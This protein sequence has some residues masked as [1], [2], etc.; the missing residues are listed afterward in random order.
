MMGVTEIPNIHWRE[1][2]WLLLS[3]QPLI[4]SIALRVRNRRRL[5][6]FADKALF[7]WLLP[8]NNAKRFAWPF[9]RIAYHT[10]WILFC[11]AASGPRY[12]LDDVSQTSPSV[13]DI[14]IVV[15]ASKSMH[16]SDVYPNR[17]RRAKLQILEVLNQLRSQRVAIIVYAAKAHL[18]VPLT[19]DYEAVRF[20]VDGL[21]KLILPTA[22]SRPM[23]A[24]TMAMQE[25]ASS[26]HAK[27]IVLLTDGDNV[28]NDSNQALAEAIKNAGIV[29]VTLG[30][31]TVEGDVIP[32]PGGGWLYQDGKAVISRLQETNLRNFAKS[33]GGY[34]ATV[35]DGDQTGKFLYD[36]VIGKN[37]DT[38]ASVQDSNDVVWRELYQWVMFPAVLL[39]FF[40]VIPYQP[41]RKP[42]TTVVG[43][44]VFALCAVLSGAN[45]AD[46]Q[47]NYDVQT[48]YSHFKNHDYAAAA[49]VFS[50]I[51]GYQGR[52]GEGASR[53][54]M[55]DFNAAVECYSQAVLDADNDH[56]R[57]VALYNLGNSYFQ[58]GNY[59]AAAQVYQDALRY[60]ERHAETLYNLAIS[61]QLDQLVK[62]RS[63]A[64]ALTGRVGRGP[65]HAPAQ[66]NLTLTDND[67]VTLDQSED[68][69]QDRASTPSL[70][71]LTAEQLEFLIQKGLPYVR[72]LGEDSQ[73]SPQTHWRRDIAANL[74]LEKEVSGR[75]WQRLFEI[76]EGFPAP[77]DTPVNEPGIPPW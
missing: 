42:N 65:R 10:A 45:S 59:A 19:H 38:A 58:A 36:Q 15:D 25:L 7:P 12:V 74:S 8:R 9:R 35:Q 68:H 73:N 39:F 11:V 28:G 64:I 70:D 76:E 16:A 63:R 30:I 3:L 56:D 29:L 57:A 62:Q 53:Y 60:R 23:E 37:N 26:P 55:Q 71:K 6:A 22:G 46:A 33:S 32:L 51:A 21:D 41:T 50:Q 66:Q 49:E 61:Q 75:V 43:I 18:Y 54:R 77:L 20:Y 34:Y 17:L 47:S 31:G 48:A 13:M 14:A 67:S 27:T 44:F 2:F 72:L 1:P 5:S 24:L 52:L 4:L 69:L 40:A